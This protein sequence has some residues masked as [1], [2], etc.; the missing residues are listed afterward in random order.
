MTRIWGA[1]VALSVLAFA[2][3]AGAAPFAQY[4]AGVTFSPLP[5]Y[6][7]NGGVN[8][9]TVTFSASSTV[10]TGAVT[11]GFSGVT[12]GTASGTLTYGALGTTTNETVTNLITFT[13]PVNSATPI[14][15]SVSSVKT[16]ALASDQSNGDSVNLY[17]LGTTSGG[18]SEGDA[19]L[20][21]FILNLVG[22][23]DV[24]TTTA[25]GT[26]SNPPQADPSLPPPEGGPVPEPISL[27][28]L[29]SGVAATLVV[30]RR[31]G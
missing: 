24:G 7:I 20:S 13:N 1:L 22:F 23:Q 8:G 4:T 3:A 15:F 12:T 6:T 29:G 2:P 21:S 16:T 31:L 14:F 9:G 17:I 5:A 25:S 27:A 11:G 30:R 19:T 10:S 18:A 26:L 28:L